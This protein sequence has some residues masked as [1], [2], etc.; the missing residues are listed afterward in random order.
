M[1]PWWIS[2]RRCEMSFILDRNRRRNWTTSFRCALESCSDRCNTQF[3]GTRV[4]VAFSKSYMLAIHLTNETLESADTHAR[5]GL[6]HSQCPV[7]ELS[8]SRPEADLKPRL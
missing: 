2:R 1:R 6:N 7:R 3:Q 4:S 5:R 8:F